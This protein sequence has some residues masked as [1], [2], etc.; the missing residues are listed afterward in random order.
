MTYERISLWQLVL[1]L[2]VSRTVLEIAN[3]PAIS[4]GEAGRDAWL[5]SAL[6]GLLGLFVV[7][8]LAA[9][10]RRHPDE[11]VF[12]YAIGLLGP[13][14]GRLVTLPFLWTFLHY[15]AFA[16]REYGEVIVTAVLPRTPIVFVMGTMIFV[17]TLAVRTGL[18]SIGRSAEILVPLFLA[19]IVT[20]VILSLSNARW[21]L[22]FPIISDGPIPLI[23]G[24]I[25]DSSPLV[26]FVVILVLYPNLSEKRHAVACAIGAALM[27][28]VLISATTMTAMAVFGAAEAQRLRFPFISL[29]RLVHL[30]EFVER[31][32]V[33]PMAAWGFG[34]FLEVSTVYWAGA[35]GMAQWLGLKD[36][37]RLTLPMG[38]LVLTLSMVLFPHT[39]QV[40]D[41]FQAEVSGLLAASLTIVPP[42]I[43]W[44]ASLLNPN[45]QGRRHS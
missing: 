2:F 27:S 19:G 15:S 29:A 10:A 39:F 45:Y 7:Y 6:A 9:L 8:Y 40:V 42:G 20:V 3:M 23:R 24:S 31:T 38:A 13:V 35:V 44:I 22:L 37:R 18:E 11:S 28:A 5:S 36:Y 12:E 1:L 14:F 33:L 21:D 16:L 43:I 17:C 41:F 4:S 26:F 25:V 34:L 30:A 32:E